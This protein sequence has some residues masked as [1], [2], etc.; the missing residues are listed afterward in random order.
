MKAFSKPVLLATAAAAVALSGCASSTPKMSNFSHQDERFF[1]A[2]TS[3]DVE[4]K[5]GVTVRNR[6][7]GNDAPVLFTMKDAGKFLRGADYA[8]A[9]CNVLGTAVGDALTKRMNVELERLSCVD[10][11]G[12]AIVSTPVKGYVYGADKGA[13]IPVHIDETDDSKILTVD[14]G[15]SATVVLTEDVGFRFNK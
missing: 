8:G 3:V 15:Q 14:G 10:G 5:Q 4:L 2:G 9:S 11:N 7:E 12:T 6:D 1:P 13:G